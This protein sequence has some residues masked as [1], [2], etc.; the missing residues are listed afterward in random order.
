LIFAVVVL[1][2]HKETSKAPAADDGC[3][4]AGC[5]EE[6]EAALWEGEESA[7]REP[8]ERLCDEA[9]GFSCFRLGELHQEGR[10]GPKNLLQAAGY[11]ERAC[12]AD[13]HEGC[14]RRHELA[15]LQD[16]A[17]A[18]L[19]YAIEACEGGRSRGCMTAGESLAEGRSGAA[20]EE[21][22]AELF[23]Q[24]CGIGDAEGCRKAGDLLYDPKGTTLNKARAVTAY[25]SACTGYDGHGCLQLAISFYEGVGTPPMLD[26]AREHF[27]DACELGVEDGCHNAKRL[28]NAK[29]TSMSLEMTTTVETMAVKGIVARDFTCRSTKYGEAGMRE[30]LGALVRH[31]RAINECVR[32]GDGVAVGIRWTVSKGRIGEVRS[33]G[34]ASKRYL[35]C[36]AKALKKKGAPGSGK[37]SAV[38]LLGDPDKADAAYPLKPKVVAPPEPT[39]ERDQGRTGK[40]GV[41]KVE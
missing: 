16:D 25:N 41:I 4:G 37:C 12:E 21:R 6:A 14:E 19:K 3:V 40:S 31:R 23:E 38:F 1:G 2:C 10:G 30:S 27:K 26:K 8:L 33:N 39:P 32:D 24:A 7:A 34:K 20:D 18:E 29:N 28:A 36:I 5:V 9:D 22:A 35:G 15:A 13:H 17:V 11:F